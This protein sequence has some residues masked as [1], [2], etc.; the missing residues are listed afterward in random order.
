MN[1]HAAHPRVSV[2]L[3]AYEAAGFIQPTLDSISA[4]TSVNFEVV[5]SVDASTDETHQVCLAHAA[6]DSRFRVFKQ[7]SRLGYV[8]NCNFLLSRAETELAMLA[9][10]DDVLAATYVEKLAAV[11][12]RSPR[13]AM[14]YSDLE[15]TQTTG[16]KEHWQFTALDGVSSR[17]ERGLRMLGRP[18]GWWVPNRGMFRMAAAR[19]VQGLKAHA[20][21]EFSTDWPWL[22]HLSLTGEF[23][24]VPETLCFKYYKPGSLSRSWKFTPAQWFEVSVSCMREIWMSDLT[25]EEKLKLAQPLTAWL[26]QNR[27]RHYLAEP[28]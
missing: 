10:H 8:G 15:L 9:F 23:V 13:A 14:S 16:A 26:M 21:G 12:G 27:P 28:K 19:R 11:L 24:R 4:Q 5:V 18:R 22:F 20:A 6:R 7:D 17:T 3:P 25:G 2:L 1:T